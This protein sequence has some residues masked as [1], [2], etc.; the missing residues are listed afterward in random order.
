MKTEKSR[1]LIL[2]YESKKMNSIISISHLEVDE[3]QV[4]VFEDID[5]ILDSYWDEIVEENQS[6]LCYVDKFGTWSDVMNTNYSGRTK[7]E[8][9]NWVEQVTSMIEEGDDFDT[10]AQKC[11]NLK[12]DIVETSS[13]TQKSKQFL[14]L[15]SELVID[16]A[17]ILANGYRASCPEKGCAVLILMDK[18]KVNVEN[19]TQVRFISRS[20]TPD[21]FRALPPHFQNS[22]ENCKPGTFYTVFM[23]V[24]NSLI[25]GFF[26]PLN[27]DR[28][29][30]N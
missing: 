26:V 5:T 12:N 25:S 2:V 23:D 1:I 8:Y 7:W 15:T 14:K 19:G 4:N 21:I 27:N 6:I 13:E 16:N 22:I 3:E 17:A 9:N 29:I 20:F 11:I 18:M 24:K 28:A 30:L 10:I